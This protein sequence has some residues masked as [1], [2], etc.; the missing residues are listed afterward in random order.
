LR[1]TFLGCGCHVKVSLS[2]GG[3]LRF[4]VHVLRGQRLNDA[5]TAES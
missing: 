3:A 4:I 1:L 5:P 2:C